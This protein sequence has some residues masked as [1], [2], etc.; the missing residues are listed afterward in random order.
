MIELGVL[1]YTKADTFPTF[2]LRLGPKCSDLFAVLYLVNIDDFLMI[3]NK[4]F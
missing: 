2:L 1:I 4:L 3:F